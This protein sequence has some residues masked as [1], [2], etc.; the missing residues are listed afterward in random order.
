MTKMPSVKTRV[1]AMTR[2]MSRRGLDR[3]T[4]V[5]CQSAIC[6]RVFAAALASKLPRSE[7]PKRAAKMSGAIASSAAASPSSAAK[8]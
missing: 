2:R 4:S 5:R 8:A 6:S 3:A 1:T 7:P